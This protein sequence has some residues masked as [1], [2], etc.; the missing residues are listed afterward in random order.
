MHLIITLAQIAAPVLPQSSILND[1]R[2]WEGLFGVAAAIVGVYKSSKLSTAQ[3]VIVATV[4]GIEYAT[5]LPQVQALEQTVKQAITA[6]ANALG[7]Q[8][9]LHKI[10]QNVT[11]TTT[12]VHK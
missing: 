3:K 11:A 8:E 6:Q 1:M 12:A 9:D 7:V 5:S 4:K 10:V 2:F